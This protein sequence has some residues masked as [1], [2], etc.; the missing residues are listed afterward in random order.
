[1]T[2]RYAPP[3]GLRTTSDPI[4]GATRIVL[5]RHGQ[6]EVNVSGVIGGIKG[7]TGLSVLGRSQ[8]SAMAERLSTSGEL[9]NVDALYA[10]ALPRALETAQLLAPALGQDPTSVIS[11]C[12]LCELHPGEADGMVWED[13]VAAYD[14]PDWDLDASQPLSPGGESWIEFVDRCADALDELAAR[15]KGQL[16]AVGTHAGFIEATVIRHLVG[17]PKGSQHPRLRL[18]TGH[19]SLT[20]WEYSDA[21]W[22]LLRYNDAHTGAAGV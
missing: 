16:V 4:E 19:A 20:E 12:M 11:E 21:G 14:A 17:S 9:A 8:V 10:S 1:M 5:I 22:R 18:R 2:S 13:F 6:G 3:E 7:C 15:H